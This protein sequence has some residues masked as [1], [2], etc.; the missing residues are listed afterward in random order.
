ME[1]RRSE[2]LDGVVTYIAN[3]G[4][5]DLSLRPLATKV[6]TTARLLIYHFDSKSQLINDVLD[7]IH[8]R[9]QRSFLLEAQQRDRR[10]APIRA[11]W[12]WAVKSANIK[13]LKVLYELQVLAAQC[14]KTYGKHLKRNSAK[15]L[16][17]IQSALPDAEH[18]LA[19]ATLYCA[20]FDGLM[21]ELLSTWDR[22]RTS[23]ALDHFVVMAAHFR[24]RRSK[25]RQ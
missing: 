24:D 22:K 21:L 11:F 4:L 15:W 8:T 12:D 9:L 25:A 23:D 6:G 1:S 3:T 7:E 16:E 19:S 20:V 5:S 14:P 2:L 13:Y 10:V 17:L 18:T